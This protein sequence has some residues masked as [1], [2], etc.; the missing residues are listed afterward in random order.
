MDTE[1]IAERLVAETDPATETKAIVEKI[2]HLQG[3]RRD[4]LNKAGDEVRGIDID[5][6]KADQSLK[7]LVGWKD[8]AAG[9]ALES[10]KKNRVDTEIMSSRTVDAIEHFTKSKLYP[11]PWVVEKSRWD[12]NES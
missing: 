6:A 9:V 11:P 2:A 1:K 10:L 5:L 3:Q 12:I 4:I 7:A 8:G